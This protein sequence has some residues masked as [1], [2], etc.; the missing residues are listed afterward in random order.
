MRPVYIG[1]FLVAL[2]AIVYVL[3]TAAS[4]LRGGTTLDRF[5]TGDLAGLDFSQAGSPAP[6]APFTNAE[7]EAV[8]LGDWRGKT[9]LV[10]FWATWCAPCEREMP[11]LGALQGAR[12]GERFDVVAISVDAREDEDYARRRLKELTGGTIDF[13]I[14]PPD[15][16][17]I[18]YAAGATGFPT[19]VIYGPDG[20]E[21]AR[22]RGEADWSAAHALGF[23]DAVT[24]SAKVSSPGQ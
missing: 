17:D 11:H 4:G 2:A 22:L 19:T 13:T 9:V 16:W 21:I 18:V 6:D 8:T 12:G 3:A 1:L 20:L 15:A 24:A 7:G 23:I 5:A 14:A 10:N